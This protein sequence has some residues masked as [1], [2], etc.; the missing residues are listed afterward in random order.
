MLQ[1]PLQREPLQSMGMNIN[2]EAKECVD[3]R[4][5][6]LWT[7]SNAMHM[8]NYY[9]IKA[10]RFNPF[11][12]FSVDGNNFILCNDSEIEVEDGEVCEICG[13]ELEEF[14]RPSDRHRDSRVLSL[15]V[16]Y[17]RGLENG[18]RWILHNRKDS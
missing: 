11:R 16:R 4:L 8:H 18:V 12:S 15:N 7:I 10:T 1:K 3:F 2:L 13:L 14:T 17:S 9:R 5:G 6:L